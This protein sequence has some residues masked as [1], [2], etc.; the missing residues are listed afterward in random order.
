MPAGERGTMLPSRIFFV[1]NWGR[2]RIQTA[3]QQRERCQ[4]PPVSSA[5]SGNL[6]TTSFPPPIPFPLWMVL[7]QIFNISSIRIC[8]HPCHGSVY[9]TLKHPSFLN[10]IKFQATVSLIDFP[11]FFFT[12]GL[13]ELGCRPGPCRATTHYSCP[14]PPIHR[15]VSRDP[16]GRLQPQR[17]LPRGRTFSCTSRPRMKFNLQLTVSAG[18]Q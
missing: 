8:K 12:V 3:R 5:V 13:L 9:H 17:E 18:P 14:P 2:G 4:G 16:S 7:K 15:D 10:I 11:S 6:R 1:S